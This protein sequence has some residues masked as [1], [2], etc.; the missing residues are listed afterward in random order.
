MFT[1]QQ[2]MTKLQETDTQE[3]PSRTL[4]AKL[5]IHVRYRISAQN[6]LYTFSKQCYLLQDQLSCFLLKIG[7]VDG[8]FVSS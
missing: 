3:I 6:G 7:G 2:P 1:L 4:Y 5:H 8:H